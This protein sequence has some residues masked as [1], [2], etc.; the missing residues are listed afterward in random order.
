MSV[1]SNLPA[2]LLATLLF[3]PGCPSGDDDDTALDDDDA[4]DDDGAVDDDDAT[5]DDD[6]VDDDDAAPDITLADLAGF[7]TLQ[8]VRVDLG[9]VEVDASRTPTS[10]TVQGREI[11]AFD[12][13]DP[14]NNPGYT[15]PV[16]YTAT[17]GPIPDLEIEG[18]W[19]MQEVTVPGSGDPVVFHRDCTAE[20]AGRGDSYIQ[21]VGSV[22][23]DARGRLDYSFVV[24]RHQTFDCSDAAVEVVATGGPGHFDYDGIQSTYAQWVHGEQATHMAATSALDA[25]ELVLTATAWAPETAAVIELQLV[26]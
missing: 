25:D 22:D 8:T 12:A 9:G 13:S 14:R 21:L 5:D 15:G 26:R 7:W 11:V 24:N 6:A 17:R 18:H 20:S 2:V 4:V 19:T 16:Q 1:R 3:S 23:Y 10:V